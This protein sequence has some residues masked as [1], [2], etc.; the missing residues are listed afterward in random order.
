MRGTSD[1]LP[2]A[3]SNGESAFGTTT[4]ALL[5]DTLS[6]F[7]HSLGAESVEVVVSLAFFA[8][9]QVAALAGGTVGV[10]AGSADLPQQVVVVSIIDPFEGTRAFVVAPPSVEVEARCAK[11][12]KLG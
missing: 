3:F 7:G 11:M 1:T 12:A 2:I 8:G 6:I 4:E 5:D 10:L 9:I